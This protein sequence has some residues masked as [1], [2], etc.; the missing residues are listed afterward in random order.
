M[1]THT[2]HH[3]HDPGAEVMPV[4]D[5][6]ITLIFAIVGTVGALPGL[7]GLL[8]SCAAVGVS[9]T[10]LWDRGFTLERLMG[11]GVGAL[12]LSALVVGYALLP[13][14]WRRFR[15]WTPWS[16]SEGLWTLTIAANSVGAT[17]SALLAALSNPAFGA[18]VALW[19]LLLVCLA[20]VAWRAERTRHARLAMWMRV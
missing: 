8:M 2:H 15:S 14:Y 17:L 9:L 19:G 13:R 1:T 20:G 3:T 12:S 4:A 11:V 5:R 18:L 6:L 7:A 16:S 10:D